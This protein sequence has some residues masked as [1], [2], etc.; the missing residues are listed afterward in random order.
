MAARHGF[1]DD[2][3]LRR[4]DK[5]R[6]VE[7]LLRRRKSSSAPASKYAG[8][9]MLRRS[10]IRPRPTNLPL[11]SR[12]SIRRR[13]RR[14]QLIVNFDLFVDKLEVPGISSRPSSSIAA[15]IAIGQ[16]AGTLISERS[17]DLTGGVFNM[18]VPFALVRRN[19]RMPP[20]AYHPDAT[21]VLRKNLRHHASLDSVEMASLA[22]SAMIQ[23]AIHADFDCARHEEGHERIGPD[24]QRVGPAGGR[25]E[26]AVD[27]D[28]R[29]EELGQFRGN[30]E[31]PAWAWPFRRASLY[32]PPWC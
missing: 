16:N 13:Q 31:L 11:A 1:L 27:D 14:P 30:N 19:L 17:E 15:P 6:G 22:R 29:S 2:S 7:H 26:P 9:L 18:S 5:V 8:H 21:T 25:H 23:E 28:Q 24:Q 10:S 32:H 3:I 4:P 12:F 20:A